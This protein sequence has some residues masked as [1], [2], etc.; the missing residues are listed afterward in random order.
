MGGS[1]GRETQRP[2]LQIKSLDVGAW[3]VTSLKGK[4]TVYRKWRRRIEVVGLTAAQYWPWDKGPERALTL[5][6][7]G[8]LGGLTAALP[9]QHYMGGTAWGGT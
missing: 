7:S 9:K 8:W 1:G 4:E 5:H 2:N 3:A 6:Y